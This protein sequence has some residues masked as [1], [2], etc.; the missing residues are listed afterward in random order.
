MQRRQ[1]LQGAFG[2]ALGA[3]LAV[4]ATQVWASPGDTRL[5]VVFLRGGYDCASVLV[6]QSSSFYYEVRP[7]IAIARPGSGAAAAIALNSD[8]ALAPALKDNLLPRFEAGQVAFVPFAGTPNMSR[9]HFETQDSV[10][11]G[12]QPGSS[13]GASRSGFMNR[14]AQSLGSVK[15]LSFTDRV[16]LIFS[17]ERLVANLSLAGARES[18][19]DARQSSMIERM[20]QGD[21]MGSQVKEGFEMRGQVS[22]ELM[23]E[24]QAASR[25]AISAKGFELQARRVAKLMRDDIRLGFIDVGGW[26][27]HTTQGD[28]AGA[29]AKRFTELGN[30]LNGFADDIGPAWKDTTVVVISE[31]GRT[32]RE[33]GN[34]GTDHGHGTVYWVLGGG[35]RGG[36]RGEQI[37]LAANTLN[38]NR[39]YPVLNDYR[40][41]LGGLLQRLYGLDANRLQAVFPKSTPRDIGLV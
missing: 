31:F 39:D 21:S 16:P 11:Q 26:D 27:S 2:T 40:D 1:L 30:G 24:M 28:G 10:E 19:I 4:G 14:L 23:G 25:N 3:S 37:K 5:L 12:L 41:V 13:G 22:R 8:W 35:V 29:L 9:S 15:T 6:P 36:V 20:Y 7:N 33:N 34:R 17:G 18:K 38:E 32:F